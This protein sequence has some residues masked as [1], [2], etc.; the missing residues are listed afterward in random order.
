MHTA[1]QAQWGFFDFYVL[2]VANQW[3]NKW[4]PISSRAQR[5]GVEWAKI[6][7]ARLL[8][9]RLHAAGQ[10]PSHE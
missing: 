10:T 7:R 9:R 1:S 3:A 8:V 6:L 4:L 5:I 2:S